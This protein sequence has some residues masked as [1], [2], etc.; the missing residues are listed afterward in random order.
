MAEDITKQPG[1]QHEEIDFDL[2]NELMLIK[3]QA[4]F[5]AQVY[6]PEDD[7]QLLPADVKFELLQSVY[8]FEE[9]YFQAMPSVIEVYQKIGEPHYLSEHCLTDAGVEVELQRLVKVMSDH[10]IIFE[11]EF[12]YHPRQLYQFITVELFSEPMED[13][14]IPGFYKHFFYEDFHPNL[15]EELKRQSKRFVTEV[16]GK[17]MDELYNGL[18]FQVRSKN[19]IINGEEACNRIQEFYNSFMS[20]EI[21]S[22]DKYEVLHDD[23]QATVSFDLVLGASIPSNENITLEGRAVLGFANVM[24]DLWLIDAVSLPGLVI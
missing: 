18:N 10:N 13:V 3:M 4:E 23:K 19:G 5:G 15:S 21:R 14:C 24:H 2:E 16:A 12:D 17:C 8:E 20:L 6:L 22:I 1:D 9:A 7:D 11:H